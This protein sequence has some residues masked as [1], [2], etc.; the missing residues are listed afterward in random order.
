MHLDRA[1]EIFMRQTHAQRAYGG[2]VSLV[3]MLAPTGS[4]QIELTEEPGVAHRL[5]VSMPSTPLL[6]RRRLSGR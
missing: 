3:T 1:A 5:V 2:K 4:Q 6:R